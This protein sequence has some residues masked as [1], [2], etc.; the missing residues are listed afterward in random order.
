MHKADNVVRV[1]HCQEV[2]MSAFAKDQK[3]KA[4]FCIS[5]DMLNYPQC[6]SMP[7]NKN[8]I[9][10]IDPF[11]NVVQYRSLPMNKDQ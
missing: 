11:F 5:Q 6:Q 4:N 8:Q 7:I 3:G 9:S 10:E 2:N 1:I